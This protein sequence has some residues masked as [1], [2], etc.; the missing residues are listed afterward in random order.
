M[1]VKVILKKVK[2]AKTTT[3]MSYSVNES[4]NSTSSKW[5][6]SEENVLSNLNFKKFWDNVSRKVEEYGEIDLLNSRQIILNPVCDATLILG[7]HP[8]FDF[9][10]FAYLKIKATNTFIMMDKPTLQNLIY[11][12]N[13]HNLQVLSE[14]PIINSIQSTSMLHNVSGFNIDILSVRINEK[15]YAIDSQTLKA[16]INH[17]ERINYEFEKLREVRDFC[18]YYIFN[19]LNTFING[20]EYNEEGYFGVMRHFFQ[21]KSK[22]KPEMVKVLLIK[23]LILCC[24]GQTAQDSIKLSEF[25]HYTYFADTI[26]HFDETCDTH[27]LAHDY[28]LSKYEM[29]NH[30]AQWI[31]IGVPILIKTLMM[32]ERIRLL[33]YASGWRHEEKFINTKELAKY[34]LWYT[35]QMD[36]VQCAFCN[37]ELHSWKPDDNPFFEHYR[38][39]RACSFLNDPETSGNVTD[40]GQAELIQMILRLKL[41]AG[42]D[43]VDSMDIN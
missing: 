31:K 34:G 16:L 12:A 11:D 28:R 39:A 27:L 15:E 17:R 22:I 43:Q 7:I 35:G 42:C 19:L 2:K 1:R 8:E 5:R 14:F 13:N 24:H 20:K 36:C 33:S 38:H 18:Q 41:N 26:Q 9:N 40:N 37:L 10:T 23:F 30:F 29:T 6:C 4:I 32:N 3:K 21:L 25:N